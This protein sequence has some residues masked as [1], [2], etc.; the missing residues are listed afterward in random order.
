MP[1]GQKRQLTRSEET[2][3]LV[4]RDSLLGQKRQPGDGQIAKATMGQSLSDSDSLN[5][6]SVTYNNA[7]RLFDKSVLA[8]G[9]L[10]LFDAGLSRTSSFS[11]HTRK[12]VDVN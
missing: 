12:Y 5:T 6:V 9:G 4:K 11:A 2:D 8:E 7:Y 3:H 1:L 10:G